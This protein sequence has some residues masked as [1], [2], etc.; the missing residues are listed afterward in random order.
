MNRIACLLIL[1]AWLAAAARG[2]AAESPL[3]LDVW[4]GKAPGEN[5]VIDEEKF[6]LSY[7]ERELERQVTGENGAF[8]AMALEQAR[9]RFAEFQQAR[10]AET[11]Q[12]LQR[13]LGAGA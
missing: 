6:H 1:F 4:P 9:A 2:P 12:A 8:V 13:L 11:D 5:G 7:V 3:V 10:R